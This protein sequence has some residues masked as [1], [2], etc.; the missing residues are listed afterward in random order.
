MKSHTHGAIFGPGVRSVRHEGQNRLSKSS[1]ISRY[2]AFIIDQW[3]VLHDGKVLYPEALATMDLLK[4]AS[5]KTIMLSN[6]SKRVGSS[7]AGLGGG[8]RSCQVL[9]RHCH[10]K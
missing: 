6:S 4:A 5:K 7:I 1:L 3:G 10:I 2:D 8:F 9:R